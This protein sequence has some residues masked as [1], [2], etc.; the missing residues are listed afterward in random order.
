MV[1]ATDGSVT[2]TY[3]YDPFGQLVRATGPYAAINPI[4]FSS[5]YYDDEVG[6][7]YYG[8]RYYSASLGKWINRDPMEEEGGLNLYAFVHNDPIG[9]FDPFGFSETSDLFWE[10]VYE[11]GVDDAIRFGQQL[12]NDVL[13]LAKASARNALNPGQGIADALEDVADKAQLLGKLS[14]SDCERKKALKD[15]KDYL[16]TPEAYADLTMKA[17]ELA[18]FRELA[19]SSPRRAGFPRKKPGCFI[20]GTLIATETGLKPIEE[21][22]EGEMVWSFNEATGEVQ[23]NPVSSVVVRSVDVLLAVQIGS[24]TVI[25]TLSHPFWVENVGWVDAGRLAIGNLI[26]LREG[27]PESV[28]NLEIIPQPTLVYNFDV[29]PAHNYFVSKEGFLVHNPGDCRGTRKPA[30]RYRGGPHS[31]TKKPS[32]DGLDS[33]HVPP[34][35]AS[36]L[37]REKGP[38]IQMEPSDHRQMPS[39]GSSASAE[40]WRDRQARLIQQGKFREAQKI[41]IDEVRRRYGE[42]YDGAIEEMLTTRVRSDDE[43]S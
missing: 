6:L 20:A 39:T 38:A 4:R 33:H 10:N 31:L 37:P 36:D 25:T 28:K 17:W 9:Y 23:L 16:S 7:S 1:K 43:D 2:A 40:K 14:A 34:D 5:K 12:A 32:G 13:D 27:E 21:I 26:K 42:K 3:E 22:K 11:N 30:K 41:E 15:L 24:E 18:A 19:R 29:E 8:Y 35:H